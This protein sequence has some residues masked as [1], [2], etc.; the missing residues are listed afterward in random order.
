MTTARV[1]PGTLAGVNVVVKVRTKPSAYWNIQKGLERLNMFLEVLGT[2]VVI[3]PTA[4]VDP[5]R[6]LWIGRW[7]WG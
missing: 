7:E 5:D 4:R 1:L 3:V 2:Q 6:W